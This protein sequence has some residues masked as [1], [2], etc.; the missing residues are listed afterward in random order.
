MHY[1]STCEQGILL[2]CQVQPRASRDRIAGLHDDRLKIQITAPPVDGKANRHLT[3][4]IAKVAGVPKS[5]VSVVR[6]E[7]SRNKTCLLQ[8]LAAL[9]D[10]LL[11]TA[12]TDT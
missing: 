5:R 10:G 11:I 6:G 12:T 4:Y 3:A 1:F 7:T 8:G 2:H 9:P